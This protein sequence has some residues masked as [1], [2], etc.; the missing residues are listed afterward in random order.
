MNQIK[1]HREI[2]ELF[3]QMPNDSKLSEATALVNENP[4]A[5]D[6]FLRNANER[7]L[8]WLWKNGFLDNIKKKTDDT[9]Q[10]SYRM[11]ELHYLARMVEKDPAKVVEILLSI[12]ISN[13]TFNPEVVD[14]FLRICG[15]LPAAHLAK[16]VPK[17]KAENWV[18]LMGVYN[19]LDFEFKAMFKTLVE[20]Q[21]F[22][23][24]LTLAEVVLSVKSKADVAAEGK[25]AGLES[26]FYFNHLTDTDVFESLL[27]VDN[28]HVENAFYIA[29]QVLINI[30]NLGTKSNGKSSFDIED[31]F[32]LFDLDFFAVEPGQKYSTYRESVVE[33]AAVVKTLAS[34]LIELNKDDE[35]K[36]LSIYDQ[37]IS[38]A[39]SDLPDSQLSWRL[40]LYLLSLAPEAYSEI[41]QEALDRIFNDSTKS[42]HDII[43]GAEYYKL[44]Q[45]SFAYL[46]QVFREEYA[47]KII[48][49]FSDL[50]KTDKEDR[51]KWNQIYGSQIL[52]SIAESLSDETKEKAKKAGFQLDLDFNP[53]PSIGSV[54][55][56]FVTEE[57]P[58]SAEELGSFSIED[59]ANKLSDD[60]SPET[61]NEKYKTDDFLRPRNAEGMGNALK[62]DIQKRLQEYIKS[63]SL[64]FDREKL[65][66]HYTYS[67]FNGIKDSIKSDKIE[68]SK[69]NWEKLFDL[70]DNI[71][72]SY[73]S[74]KFE[75]SKESSKFGR[76]WL[77]DW[78]AVHSTMVDVLRELL[79]DNGE[80]AVINLTTYRA[81]IFK[82]LEYLLV[83]PDPIFADEKIETAKMTT[84]SPGEDTYVS[85]PF[86][87]AIN[88]V[89]GR[90]FETF[91]LFVYQDGKQFDKDA[92]IKI[93]D[94]CKTLYEDVLKK[95]TTRAIMFLFGHNLPTF[96]YRDKDWVK[97]LLPLIFPNQKDKE[98]LYSAAW[99]GYLSNNLYQEIFFEPEFEKLYEV[100]ISLKENKL[101][102]QKPFVELDEGIATHLALAFIHYNRFK[103][104]DSLFTKFLA[105]ATSH[106]MAKF[107]G[108]IGRS[109]ISGDNEKLDE[110]VQKNTK[111][112]QK[113]TW[114]WDWVLTNKDEIEI[115]DEF[116]LWINIDKDIFEIK[117]LSKQLVKTLKKTNGALEWELGLTKAIVKFANTSPKETIEIA[118]LYLLDGLL[119]RKRGSMFYHIDKEWSDAFGILY[120]NPE[121]KKETYN[122]IN[123]LIL[124]GGSVFWLLEKIV[125]EEDV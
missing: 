90:A 41:I 22:N 42:F 3:T 68:A 107:I 38:F 125:K 95:E 81:K 56:G 11:P 58:V 118:K 76:S 113:L 53:H 96:Y 67:Y 100:G 49:Y 108:F 119:S 21:D 39:N 36:L 14:Q 121:T 74:E 105:G 73:N 50:I 79:S 112:K 28:E 15:D 60:W 54:V 109:V 75:E 48:E 16:I 104:T 10:Y 34:R 33:L 110:F 117:W 19:H 7:W 4:D 124:K 5:K 86:T 99:E 6:F 92:T 8:D 72:E 120:T 23:S 102:K 115:L 98:L 78:N 25:Q 69:I 40:R 27:S 65:N 2:E 89:R 20:A 26:P 31:I 55:G 32:Y 30:V 116:G 71:I 114:L 122:L 77:A 83:Y 84:K 91:T 52:T 61:L 45:K 62:E 93:S 57:S 18:V 29:L 80:K 88:S 85:D 87:I 1:I 35:N 51:K 13:D 106:Q 43:G 44:L 66:S 47:G 59:I 63:A 24:I 64:F 103:Q 82:V 46:P 111:V 94:D 12:K 123:N 17:I 37:K 9:S 97:R 70:F 101:L